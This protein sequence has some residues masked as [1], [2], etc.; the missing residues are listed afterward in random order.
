MDDRQGAGVSGLET[1]GAIRALNLQSRA[2]SRP[3]GDGSCNFHDDFGVLHARE[4]RVRS[5]HTQGQSCAHG[6]RSKHQTNRVTR[7]AGEISDRSHGKVLLLKNN[8]ILD[9]FCP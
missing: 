3:F 1:V 5:H 8:R 4:R 2:P 6:E 7:D 9:A